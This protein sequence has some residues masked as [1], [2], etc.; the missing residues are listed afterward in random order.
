MNF[1][2]QEETDPHFRLLLSLS[3]LQ[4]DC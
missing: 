1:D 4:F 3:G 2:A